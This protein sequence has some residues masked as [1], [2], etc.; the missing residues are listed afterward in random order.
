MGG[1]NMLKQHRNTVMAEEFSD[2]EDCRIE[3]MVLSI[4]HTVV[5]RT[6]TDNSEELWWL[7]LLVVQEQVPYTRFLVSGV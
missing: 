7:K 4:Y 6:D 3:L 2:A 1:I 5:Q